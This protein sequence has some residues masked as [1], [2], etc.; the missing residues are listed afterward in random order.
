LGLR[1]LGEKGQ[2]IV[3]PATDL[4]TQ[5]LHSPVN[6][7]E[8]HPIFFLREQ[9]VQVKMAVPHAF[10]F[11][12]V[13]MEAVKMAATEKEAEAIWTEAIRERERSRA[14]PVILTAEEK[15][16]ILADYYIGKASEVLISTGV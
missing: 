4:E 16:N 13:E 11:S 5:E 12:M 2:L 8:S 14:K 1:A 9:G 10:T 3:M 7:L 6:T 15:I